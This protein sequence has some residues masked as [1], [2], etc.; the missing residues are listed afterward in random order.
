M[1]NA[2]PYGNNVLHRDGNMVYILSFQGGYS[3]LTGSVSYLFIDV[4]KDDLN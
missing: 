1:L 3:L 2:F 4:C